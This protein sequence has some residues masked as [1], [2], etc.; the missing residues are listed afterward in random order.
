MIDILQVFTPK[1]KLAEWFEYYAGALEL[2]VWGGTTIQESK[3]DDDSG[4]WT[5]TVER[6]MNGKKELR[7]N[8]K[9]IIPR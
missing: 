4:K 6:K 9:L 7:K 8:F 2:N 5:V 1:D 3:Y